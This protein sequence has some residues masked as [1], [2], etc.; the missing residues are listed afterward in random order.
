MKETDKDLLEQEYFF[1]GWKAAVK[2]KH[3]NCEGNNE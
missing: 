1:L 2:W 3:R